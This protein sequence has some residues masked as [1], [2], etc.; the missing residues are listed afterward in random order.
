MASNRLHARTGSVFHPQPG[1]RTPWQFSNRPDERQGIF[2]RISSWFPR[3]YRTSTSSC[4]IFLNKVRTKRVCLRRQ[5]LPRDKAQASTISPTSTI[6]PARTCFRNFRH[7]SALQSF[8]KNRA[9]FQHGI[10]RGRAQPVRFP[11]GPRK[12]AV[13]QTCHGWNPKFWAVLRACFP[14]PESSPPSSRR[15]MADIFQP[16]AVD[17]VQVMPA[18]PAESTAA[19]EQCR[20][21]LPVF[22]V[23]VRIMSPLFIRTSSSKTAYYCKKKRN[24]PRISNAS[25]PCA[26]FI[27]AFQIRSQSNFLRKRTFIAFPPFSLQENRMHIFNMLITKRLNNIFQPILNTAD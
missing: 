2:S 14:N 26:A 6:F 7:S 27:C 24:S 5:R 13:L 3:R 19:P 25:N 10:P 9:A 4:S 12:P 22:P 23:R 16:K 11:P 18:A 15:R 1:A 21:G 8:V 20:H 17:A